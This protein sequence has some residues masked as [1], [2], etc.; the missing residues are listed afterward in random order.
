MNVEEQI[1]EY[2]DSQPKPK[3]S[4]M[5]KLHQ[6]ILEVMTLCKLWSLDGKND[7]GKTVYN[8]NIGYGNQTIKYPNGTTKAFYQIGFSANKTGISVYILGIKDKTDLT[9]TY[10]KEIG[11]ASI[12]GYCIKFKTQKDINIE[13]LQVAMQ[14]G[15]QVTTL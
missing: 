2:I 5:H 12:T 6:I 8:P 10:G 7:K 4:D 14:Y 13:I 11:K 9:Q 1:H 3:R 15:I